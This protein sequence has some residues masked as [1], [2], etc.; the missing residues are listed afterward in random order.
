MVR[1]IQYHCG[2]SSHWRNDINISSVTTDRPL[3]QTYDTRPTVWPHIKCW[4]Q[5]NGQLKPQ[6]D[7][8]PALA[9][10]YSV[11]RKNKCSVVC[12]TS[13]DNRD[14]NMNYDPLK[15]HKQIYDNLIINSSRIL[16]KV[17]FADGQAPVAAW[18]GTNYLFRLSDSEVPIIKRHHITHEWRNKLFDQL[19][20]LD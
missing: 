2:H 5:Q 13:R 18:Q 1:I 15:I 9:I 8:T 11:S 14:E 19:L 4:P 17:Q 16:A 20:N 3:F 10:C 6:H 7:Q 12:Y